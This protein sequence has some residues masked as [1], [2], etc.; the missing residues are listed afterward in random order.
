MHSFT[1]TEGGPTPY[2]DCQLA[3]GS[4]NSPPVP[5][6][7]GVLTPTAR[8]Q[9]HASRE[10]VTNFSHNDYL[11]ESTPAQEQNQDAFWGLFSP[12]A[13]APRNITTDHPSSSRSHGPTI[14][15][16]PPLP[17]PASTFPNHGINPLTTLVDQNPL[18]LNGS[19]SPL[20]PMPFPTVH[21]GIRDTFSMFS[22]PHQP[23]AMPWSGQQAP[24]AT[25]GNFGALGSMH[26]GSGAGNL[27]T[28]S[29]FLAPQ[30]NYMLPQNYS[31]IYY[32]PSGP[33]PQ[34]EANGFNPALPP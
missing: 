23:V 18:S 26:N 33:A 22:P 9:D 5:T 30:P 25:F 1:P 17:T 32:N 21:A 27:A 20:V 28:S 29:N 3:L 7:S 12:S 15:F 16:P 24:F 31:S 14:P 4:G 2:S 34:H 19:Q 8:V 6:P 10:T 11:L 13:P